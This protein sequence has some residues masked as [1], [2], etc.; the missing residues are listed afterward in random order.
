[1]GAFIPYQLHA[2]AMHWGIRLAISPKGGLRMRT[3][4]GISIAA[5]AMLIAVT[6]WK[7]VGNSS[8]ITAHAEV[9]R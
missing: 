4:L 2:I 8:P 6:G 7:I 5:I 3:V 1:L 9:F